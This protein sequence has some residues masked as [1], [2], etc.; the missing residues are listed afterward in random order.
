[1]KVEA[2]LNKLN[3]R[4]IKLLDSMRAQEMET[5]RLELETLK[6][7]L[8]KQKALGEFDIDPEEEEGEE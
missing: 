3:G 4:I 1:M 6:Y 2:E 5:Q 7:N 8:A